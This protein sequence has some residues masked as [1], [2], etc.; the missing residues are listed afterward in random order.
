MTAKKVIDFIIEQKLDLEDYPKLE[1]PLNEK[2]IIYCNNVIGT[3]DLIN[4]VIR[5][6]RH[7]LIGSLEYNIESSF[8]IFDKKSVGYP[9]FSLPDIMYAINGAQSAKNMPI[10]D[11]VLIS[12]LFII[13]ELNNCPDY[14]NPVIVKNKINEL[15]QLLEKTRGLLL[16]ICD[17]GINKDII[18][19]KKVFKLLEEIESK[20][21][22]NG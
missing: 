16:E 21:K 1:T 14:S 3:K 20:N 9:C 17:Y 8:D 19:S 10:N 13:Q 15:D 4:M 6:E 11:D 12:R 22:I 2:F 18:L 5:W 7:Q